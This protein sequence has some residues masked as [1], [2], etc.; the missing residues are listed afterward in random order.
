EL[1]AVVPQVPL[2]TGEVVAGADEPREVVSLLDPPVVLRG[3]RVP[4]EER[5]GVAVL[6]RLDLGG[7]DAHLPFG[8]EPDVAVDVD[9]AGPH[10]ALDLARRFGGRVE[11]EVAVDHPA[12][13]ELGAVAD[14][15]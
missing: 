14:D 13:V 3:A 6:L 7:R 1:A 4:D 11:G 2:G 9:E 10:P 12:L 15:D 5:A 8:P